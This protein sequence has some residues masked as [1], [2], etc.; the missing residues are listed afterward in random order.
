M[1]KI[2]LLICASVIG[3]LIGGMGMG[4]G[5]LMIPLLT[6]FCGIDQ[7]AAQAINLV[8][9]IPMSVIALVIHSK[10]KLV[11]YKKVLP[12]VLPSLVTSV[13][14]SFWALKVNGKLLS[15]LYGGFL[16]LLGI[17]QLTTVIISYVKAQENKKPFWLPRKTKQDSYDDSFSYRTKENDSE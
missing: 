9:F 16:I 14:C 4:G 5:T 13:L 6:I 3:G 8:A 1:L 2:I 7:H 10:N 12:V 17:Y 15:K 11:E